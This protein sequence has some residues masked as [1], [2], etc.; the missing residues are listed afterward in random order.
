MQPQV[1]WDVVAVLRP[2]TAYRLY[3]LFKQ[4]SPPQCQWTSTRAKSI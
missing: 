2:S 1:N 4:Q 3:V